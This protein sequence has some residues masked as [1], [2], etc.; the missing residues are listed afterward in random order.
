[1]HVHACLD[2]IKL[3]RF[4]NVII[5]VSLLYLFNVEEPVFILYHKAKYTPIM[6]NVTLGS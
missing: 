2:Y 1:M 6:Q 3:F 5:R 4:A